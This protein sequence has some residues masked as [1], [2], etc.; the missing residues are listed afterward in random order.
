MK[1]IT[2]V[3]VTILALGGITF[4][5]SGN[6]FSVDPEFDKG[7]QI[8]Q[9]IHQERI[10]IKSQKVDTSKVL[11][12]MRMMDT[13]KKSLKAKSEKKELYEKNFF[14]TKIPTSNGGNEKELSR[15]LVS[16]MHGLKK[17][18]FNFIY[19]PF[20]G[21]GMISDQMMEQNPSYKIVVES[22]K[23]TLFT[24]HPATG[25]TSRVAEKDRSKILSKL[26]IVV[27]S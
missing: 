6:H 25:K 11:S 14:F 10:E 12:Q 24:L 20:S 3:L 16:R 8:S 15:I 17:G 13:R 23:C 19:R 7:M 5:I 4:A 22:G 2:I 27:T 18:E 26:Q 1:K 21:E 9:K